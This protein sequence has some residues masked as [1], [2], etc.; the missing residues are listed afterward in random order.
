ML[1]DDFAAKVAE[2]DA[3]AAAIFIT[4]A[5]TRPCAPT[6]STS[7]SPT[8]SARRASARSSSWRRAST[9]AP[10]GWTGRQAR[11]S[12]RST[13]PRCS[14][15]RRPRSPS[16]ARSRRRTPRRCRSTCASTGR[17]PCATRDSTPAQPTAWLAEGLLMYLPADA[18]DRLFEQVTALSAAG[19]R[20]AAE[21]V[22]VHAEDRREEMRERFERI[23]EQFGMEDTARHRGADLRRPRP[24]RRR[25][26]ARRA[27]L[28]VAT[29]VDL[30][31]RDAP[32]RP[33]GTARAIVRRRRVLALRHRREGP[34]STAGLL[35]GP[36]GWLG[37]GDPRVRKD[38][39][40]T[41]ESVARSGASHA[42]HPRTVAGCARRSRP[43]A[44]AASNGASS[45]CRRWRG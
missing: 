35:S 42:R 14:S 22:G 25:G 29:P 26:M 1:D 36:T 33:V 16:T 45:S 32:A 6:S 3:E 31:G 10:T 37:S 24:R 13:S 27:R 17:R 41:T 7:S 5:A 19:S 20:I 28:A 11:R 4:W 34:G 15:T 18:Q 43:A 9:R 21:T 39:T 30:A 8:A 40:M 23:A 2:V 12:T 38:P 44:P